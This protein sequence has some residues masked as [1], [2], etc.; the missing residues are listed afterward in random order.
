MNT[1][2][3]M[4]IAELEHAISDAL[5]RSIYKVDYCRNRGLYGSREEAFIW[6][7]EA[8]DD[9]RQICVLAGVEPDAL[10][11]RVLTGRTGHLE[12]FSA[13]TRRRAENRLKGRGVNPPRLTCAA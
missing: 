2:H 13:R 10:R 6:S 1:D 11:K 9:Y 4:C 3:R 8:G 5:G 12:G 7:R